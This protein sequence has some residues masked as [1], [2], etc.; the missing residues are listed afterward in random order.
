MNIYLFFCIFSNP[1][2]CLESRSLDR[3][4]NQCIQSCREMLYSA[5]PTRSM[6]TIAIIF[7]TI[8]YCLSTFK[9]IFL[10]KEDCH[11]QQVES[12][13]KPKYQCDQHLASLIV[14]LYIPTSQMQ[15]H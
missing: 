12:K 5:H 2:Y 9:S 10:L 4:T 15:Q 6:I 11:H 3:N 14:C 13:L 7:S 8:K 1:G